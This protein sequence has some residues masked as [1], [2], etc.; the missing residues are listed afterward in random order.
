VILRI[1][2]SAAGGGV[3]Q[4]NCG[5][6]N[7][8]R[9]RRGEAP[10]RTQSSIAVSADGQTWMLV[11]ISVDVGRQLAATPELWPSSAR[12][13]PFAAVF[14]TD[15]NVDHTA[16]LSELRQDPN[17]FVVVSTSV[18]KS[19]LVPQLAYERFDRLPH[20]WLAFEPGD[21][22]IAPGIGEAVAAQFEIQMIP[23]PGLLPGYAGREAAAGA[24]V[25]Y[26]LRDRHAGTRVLVAPVFAD[27]DP[28]LVGLASECEAVLLDGSFF[29]DDEMQRD[30]LMRKTA[31]SLG[32]APIAG[33][34]GTLARIARLRNRRI[35]VHVNNSNPVLDPAS[36]EA[37]TVAAAGCEI[38]YDGMRISIER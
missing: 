29:Y 32:H 4:W 16:G 11:N 28:R 15:A 30:G 9:A 3:P 27:F 10:A 26:M 36:S 24:V 12:A 22:D 1:L 37:K 31:R 5:C 19:L 23:V 21:D 18:V 7:C 17:P 6:G 38:A 35:F 25:A 34:D 20:R 14:L 13:T 2:G 8:M 33:D